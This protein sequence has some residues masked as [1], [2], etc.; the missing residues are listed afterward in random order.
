MAVQP[1][2]SE[3]S[4]AAQHKA[5]AA[6]PRPENQLSTQL[7][8]VGFEVHI[9]GDAGWT[10]AATFDDS[11]PAMA[12]AR[13]QN[14][15]GHCSGVRVIKQT[16]DK[17]SGESFT[18]T[19]FSSVNAKSGRLPTKLRAP[20]EGAISWRELTGLGF[21]GRHPEV[22]IIAGLAMLSGTTS[23]FFLKLTM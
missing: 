6:Q 10:T 8:T 17:T 1:Q 21:I 3:T 2:I 15:A 16:M 13:E 4:V 12:E 9:R 7:A 5:Q 22:V 23:W 18:R 14:A 11:E 19:I 20:R